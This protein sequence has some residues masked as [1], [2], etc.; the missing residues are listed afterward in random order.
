MGSSA[1]LGGA[2]LLL[3][4]AWGSADFGGARLGCSASS[5]RSVGD[6]G[7]PRSRLWQ[8]GE[9][10]PTSLSSSPQVP[11]GQPR[12]ALLMVMVEA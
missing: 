12:L 11:A 5:C 2:C 8:L 3:G 1:D 4:V 6:C 10:F 7:W 9:H